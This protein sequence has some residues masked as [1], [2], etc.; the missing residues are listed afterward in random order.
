MQF[1]KDGKATKRRKATQ[2]K[3]GHT[4]IDCIRWVLWPTLAFSSS[5]AFF[6]APPPI[7]MCCSS[8]PRVV[9]H[10]ADQFPD[11]RDLSERQ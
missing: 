9:E 8:A 2:G 3:D 5:F 1:V 7:L 6:E 4:L 11:G 10:R